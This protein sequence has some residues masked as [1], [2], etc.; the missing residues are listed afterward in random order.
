MKQQF[1]CERRPKADPRN[2]VLG[3]N[4]RITFLTDR[5]VRFEYNESGAFVD[6][7]SQVIWYRDLEEVPFEIKQKNNFLEIQTKSI[8]I[9]Y[10]ERAFDESIL[11]VKLKKPD[12]GCDRNGIMAEKRI[13]IFS[14]LPVRSM[15]QTAGSDW[16]KEFFPGMDLQY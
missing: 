13:V 11:S 9:R 4:Y 7:A 12:N 16:K 14:E 10:D 8:R 2:I 3:K 5:L 6:E 1:I 15:K